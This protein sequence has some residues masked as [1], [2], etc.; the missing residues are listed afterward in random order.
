MN[1]LQ[2]DTQPIESSQWPLPTRLIPIIPSIVLHS[3][4]RHVQRPFRRS[5]W[6]WTDCQRSPN[7]EMSSDESRPQVLQCPIQGSLYTLCFP[8]RPRTRVWPLAGLMSF[9]PTESAQQIRQYT[10]GLHERSQS[11]QLEYLWPGLV[12]IEFSVQ[13]TN[14]YIDCYLY[15]LFTGSNSSLL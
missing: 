15:F 7:A 5:S 13:G 4:N 10:P 1:V 6:S 11:S 14:R 9:T 12:T 8:V 2:T 3:T